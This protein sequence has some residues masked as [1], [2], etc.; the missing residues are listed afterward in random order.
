MKE[1]C[2]AELVRFCKDA[3]HGNARAIRCLQVRV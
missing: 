2:K 1:A 3:P